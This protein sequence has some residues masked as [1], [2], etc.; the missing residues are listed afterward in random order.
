MCSIFFKSHFE[1]KDPGL[2]L[3]PPCT[4]RLYICLSLRPAS[5]SLQTCCESTRYQST[6]P[7]SPQTQPLTTLTNARAPLRKKRYKYVSGITSDNLSDFLNCIPLRLFKDIWLRSWLI[8]IQKTRNNVSDYTANGWNS[9][10]PD[11]TPTGAGT[12][13]AVDHVRS[14][15]P[16]TTYQA[17]LLK[18][19]I[20]TASTQTATSISKCAIVLAEPANVTTFQTSTRAQRSR[21][22]TFTTL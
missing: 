5:T 22:V 3:K 7:S 13:T 6:V 20:R 2:C 16:R 14:G 21:V 8:S 1:F 9:T 12:T 11:T 17:Y 18:Y 19:L 15:V 4:R 10:A